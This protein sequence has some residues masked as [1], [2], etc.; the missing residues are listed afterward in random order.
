MLVTLWSL[1]HRYR[2]LDGDAELYAVQALAR[3]RRGLANDLFLQNLSQDRYTIFS[4]LYA[5]CIGLFGLR[6][7]AMLLTVVFKV[8]FF[9][10]AWWLARELSNRDTAFL[11]TALLIVTGGAYGAF[12]VFHYSEDWV[13]ARSMAEALVITALALHFH[14]WKY[15]GLLASIV[16]LFVHP[17][18]ALPVF[19]LLVCLWLPLRY[20]A[21]GAAAGVLVSLGIAA[22][23]LAPPSIGQVFTVI[24]ADWLE[25]VR[26]RSQ[27]L[28]LQLWKVDDWKLTALPFLS[29]TAS[30]AAIS[31]PRI[32]KLCL[33]A[34]L[35][36][37]AGLAVALIAGGIGPIAILLQ[38]Q[39]WRWVWIA[40]F[41]SVLL[42][43]PTAVSMWRD[44]KCGPLCALLMIAA[45]TFPSVDGDTCVALALLLWS[46]RNRI[47]GQMTR[48][49]QMAAILLGAVVI[50]WIVANFWTTVRSPLP[51]SGRESVAAQLTKNFMGLEGLS[52]VLV[53]SLATWI[54]S[55]QSLVALGAVSL[56]FL[57]VTVWLLP[58]T[59]TDM[60]R[61]GEMQQIE[62]FASWRNVI[63]A[64]ANVFVV[65]AHNSA[66]F[67]W[68]TLERPSYLTV[69]QSSGVV[70]S[71]AT[72]LEVR[73][74]SDV[75]L[76]L[77]D[78]DWRLLSGMK[79]YHGS[80]AGMPGSGAA[81]RFPRPL[82]RDRLMS[83]CTDPQL[84]FV[85]AKDNVGFGALGH[86]HAGNWRDWY[87]YD[88][89]RVVAET[90]AA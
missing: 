33:A 54:R 51:E 1:T 10:S 71:R 73:R 66:A 36:A 86:D 50:M 53:W 64:S 89:R 47:N 52:V 49:T 17:L 45:W 28:F 74:R 57:G 62:E 46:V 16:A 29:L 26:E 58:G 90:P 70:F 75:L 59:F 31:D 8:W 61:D 14:G 30:A 25:V 56:A 40:S 43:A 39:A 87:L 38:G 3:I 37:A 27:F 81:S 85:V 4:P 55:R 23:S 77:V 24:D 13:T 41:F 60:N 44:A 18:M 2:A 82:T 69:D 12:N 20:G 76:P 22:T 80:G 78:P 7:A 65:P 42:L 88:C 6:S 19:L 32:R 84:N 79:R 72:A 35:V 83:I 68:F 5:W 48:Y 11:A 34:M 63:P 9:T 15:T 67:A 21:L